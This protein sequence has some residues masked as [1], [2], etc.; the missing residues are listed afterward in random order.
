MREGT[1]IG[2]LVRGLVAGTAGAGAQDGFFR[3]TARLAPEAPRVFEP[4]DPEQREETA[5]ET[6][7]RRLAALAGRPPLTREQKRRLARWVHYGFGAAWGALYGLGHESWRAR[8][9]WA[10][11]LGFSTAVW[12]LGDNLLLAALGLAA[13]PQKYPLRLHAYA[14]AAHV[15]YGAA[16]AGSYRALDAACA[17][18]AAWARPR[19]RSSAPRSARTRAR[20]SVGSRSATSRCR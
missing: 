12:M 3:A 18:I 11:V 14:L 5:L 9:R 7:A 20:R 2:A 19:F 16:V 17:T 1:P 8:R 6:T 10:G 4:R 15:A 13:P